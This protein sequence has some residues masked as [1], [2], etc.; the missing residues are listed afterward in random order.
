[1]SQNPAAL[2]QSLVLL[3][4]S[5]FFIYFL[6]DISYISDY[7][8]FCIFFVGLNTPHGSWWVFVAPE[9]GVITPPTFTSLPHVG[10]LALMQS[11]LHDM[12]ALVKAMGG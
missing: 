9:S 2:G 7:Q 1:M 6:G 4:N 8:L 10:R 5:H 12:S 11:K 3:A